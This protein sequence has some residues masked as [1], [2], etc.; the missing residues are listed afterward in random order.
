MRNILGQSPLNVADEMKQD[1]IRDVLIANEAETK[2]VQLPALE[3]DYLGQKPPGDEPERFATG[4]VSSI[5]GL[6]S[7]VAFSPDE[8]MAL[9]SPMVEVPGQIYSTG[10]IMMMER[11]NGRWLLPRWAPF[12][13]EID[14]D[15]PFFSP[16]GNRIYFMSLRALPDDPESRKERIWYV[17]KIGERWSQMQAVDPVVND[18]P[19]HWQFSV[20]SKHTIY[21]SSN[22]PEG[23]GGGDLYCSKFV[24]GKWQKPENLGSP[25]NTTKG[26]GTPYI[27][28]DGSYLIFQRDLDLYISFHKEDGGWT[29]AKSLEA[30]I[31][32]SSYELCPIVTPDEKYLFFLSTRGGESHAWWVDAGFIDRMKSE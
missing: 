10:G 11:K 9:W 22:V 8:D 4:I 14:G 25:I 29:Q 1:K 24:D 18:Y 5:W 21:F 27:A 28:P 31:N 12:S 30:P 7:T 32:S 20:D 16:D 23:T 17:E 15:V 6:H 13:G 2:P 3:G 26:E 19:H